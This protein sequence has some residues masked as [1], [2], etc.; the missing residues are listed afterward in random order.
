MSRFAPVALFLSLSGFVSPQDTAQVPPV[1]GFGVVPEATLLSRSSLLLHTGYTTPPGAGQEDG[2]GGSGNQNYFG[3]IGW[4]A[5]DQLTIFFGVGINDDPTFAPIRG[6]RKAQ[7]HLD[8]SLGFRT[9]LGEVGRASVGLQGTGELMWIASD[10]GLWNAGT[11]YD[12]AL[13]QGFALAVPI[14]ARLNS[15]WS[16]TIVPSIAH[17]PGEVMGA[18]YY[19]TMVRLGGSVRA[20]VSETWI[21]AGSAELPMGPGYNTIHRDGRLSR[22]PTWSVDVRFRGTPRTTLEAR[23]TNSAGSTPSRRHL[24]QLSNPVTLYS[25][26]LRYSPT[27]RESVPESTREPGAPL[28]SLGGITVPAAVTLP[29]RGWRLSTTIDSKSAASVRLAW[30]FGH[31]FQFELLTT[32]IQ[33]PDAEKIMKIPIGDG[34]Q[35]LFGPQLLLFDQAAGA[36]LSLGGRV[37]VGREWKKQGYLLGEAVAVRELQPGLSL[38]LNP[39]FMQSGA[40]SLATVAVAGRFRVAAFEVLPEWRG[41]FS[42]E[43]PVWALGFRLPEFGRMVADLFVTNAAGTFGLGRLLSDPDGARVGLA[44]RAT[45]SCVPLWESRWPCNVRESYD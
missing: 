18:Q 41:S 40:R 5:T 19:G 33:G 2:G 4:G 39:L 26:A 34:H 17:L 32:R 20:Q 11:E 12:R 3:G 29:P 24:T 30:A 9:G 16:A 14:T 44:L 28:L 15:A 38:I 22:V 35:I 13:A 6:E 42:G 1:A 31:R 36:P 23:L 10:P 25:V 37:I 21:L 45:L 7:E 8:L 27:E 43:R